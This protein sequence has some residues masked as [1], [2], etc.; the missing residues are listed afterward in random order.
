MKDLVT[1]IL[2]EKAKK[3][4]IIKNKLITKDSIK[5]PKFFTFTFFDYS[6][7]LEKI[8]SDPDKFRK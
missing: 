7:E 2:S 3:K 6:K 8:I 4:K 1:F 5:Q